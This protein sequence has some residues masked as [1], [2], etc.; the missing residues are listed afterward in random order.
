MWGLAW[1]KDQHLLARILGSF[2]CPR[3]ELTPS[4]AGSHSAHLEP[5]PKPFVTVARPRS[6]RSSPKTRDGCRGEQVLQQHPSPSGSLVPSTQSNQSLPAQLP[7]ASLAALLT[8]QEN[9]RTRSQ[10]LA[11]PFQQVMKAR[12]WK[13]A[14]KC[15]AVLRGCSPSP[16]PSSCARPGQRHQAQL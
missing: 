12:E 5:F 10:P 4:G 3:G 1:G 7:P 16:R 2:H 15:L 11:A 8:W 14:G 13:M 6:C 9:T